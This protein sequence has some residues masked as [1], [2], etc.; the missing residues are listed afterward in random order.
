MQFRDGRIL[1]TRSFLSLIALIVVFN[2]TLGWA[3]TRWPPEALLHYLSETWLFSRRLSDYARLS[4]ESA[5]HYLACLIGMPIVAVVYLAGMWRRYLPANSEEAQRLRREDKRKHTGPIVTCLF[6]V[7]AVYF[8][9]FM[10]IQDADGR[11]IRG[12]GLLLN[13]VLPF[14]GVLMTIVLPGFVLGIPISFYRW[15]RKSEE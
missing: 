5:Y 9:L 3:F 11:Y 14:W 15:F 6:V 8:Y 13:P 10:P 4:P 2:L 7:G 12:A 1:T